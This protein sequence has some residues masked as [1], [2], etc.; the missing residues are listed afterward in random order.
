MEFGVKWP[1]WVKLWVGLAESK[2]D[3]SGEKECNL[4]RLIK[5]KGVHWSLSRVFEIVAKKTQ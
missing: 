1:S 5:V 3:Q 4:V 2:E